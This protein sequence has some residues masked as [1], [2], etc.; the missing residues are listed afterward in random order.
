MS[1]INFMAQVSNLTIM[2][3]FHDSIEVVTSHGSKQKSLK[4]LPAP[5]PSALG[6]VYRG[7]IGMAPWCLASFLWNVQ[8]YSHVVA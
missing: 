6:L 5:A 2:M 8:R 7:S 1:N 4:G 3:D